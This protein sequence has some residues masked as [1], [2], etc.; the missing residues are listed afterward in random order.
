[1]QDFASLQ[2][3][4]PVPDRQPA[5][6][7]R[8]NLRMPRVLLALI[9]APLLGGVIMTFLFYLISTIGRNESLM[10]LDDLAMSVISPSLWS[11]VCGL[12]YLQT[13]TRW[14][15]EIARYECLLLGFGSSF[16]FPSALFGSM[17]LLRGEPPQWFEWG[18]LQYL[19]MVGLICAPFGVLGGW[20]FWRLGIRPAKAP[21]TDFAAVFD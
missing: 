3:I 1:M 19:A 10:R 8:K 9:V 12:A 5:K 4:I 14:R 16:L 6:R 2:P 20:L 11:L 7:R 13:I 18:D 21:T 17:P 15:G